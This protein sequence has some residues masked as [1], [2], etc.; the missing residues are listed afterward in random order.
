MFEALGAQRV[1][2]IF[3]II[4]VLLS[5]TA[6]AETAEVILLHPPQIDDYERNK[7]DYDRLGLT[8]EAPRSDACI[9][10]KN[11]QA[12]TL[13]NLPLFDDNGSFKYKNAVLHSINLS[14]IHI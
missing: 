10:Y 3:F 6:K 13:E 8:K 7:E 5:S 2:R 9:K 11:E 4:A 12:R 1:M 14:L